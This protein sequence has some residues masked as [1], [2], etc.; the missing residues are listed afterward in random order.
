MKFTEIQ[1]QNLINRYGNWALVTGASSGIGNELAKEL[2]LSGFNLILNSRNEKALKELHSELKSSKNEIETVVGD[3]ANDSVISEILS[4]S[5]KKDLGLIVLSAGFGTSGYFVKGNLENEKKML[6]VNCESILTLVT[7]F[8]NRFVQQ[9]RGGIVLFSSVVAFQGTP[10][11]A[12]YA[13][14][15]AYIQVLGE[16]LYE[17]L[18]MHNVDVTL[19]ALGPVKSGFESKANLKMNFSML[20][21]QVAIP[22]LKGIGKNSIV[23]PGFLSK[24]LIFSLKTA[25]RKL[26]VKIMGLVMGGMTKHQRS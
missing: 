21:S 5:E 14:T 26:K 18:K 25:P 4:I 19:A 15:K 13:A 16:G 8:S 10:Y 17:E 1:R 9:R 2:A 24:L 20:P 22:I 23:Y 11:S 3:I 6:Q 12:H 7:A